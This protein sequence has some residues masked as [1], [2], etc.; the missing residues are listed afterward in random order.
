MAHKINT[1]HPLKLLVPGV[2]YLF[3]FMLVFKCSMA[4]EYKL[5]KVTPLVEI[6]GLSNVLGADGVMQDRR[7]FVWISSSN[8]LYK[9]DGY[10]TTHYA[11]DPNQPEKLAGNWTHALTEDDAGNIWIGI[12]GIGLQK[13]DPIT[14]K[15]TLYKADPAKPGGLVSNYIQSVHF[16]NGK[17]WICTQR[18]LSA[19]SPE[20]EKFK[21][22]SELFTIQTLDK[23]KETWFDQVINTGKR[24]LSYYDAASDSCVTLDTLSTMTF[25]D[26][27]ISIVNDQLFFLSN[28]K[29]YVYDLKSKI[30][31]PVKIG[32][33]DAVINVS[34]TDGQM[35]ILFSTGKIEK[36]NPE[37]GSSVMFNLG[38]AKERK[39][40]KLNEIF[41]LKNGG[42]WA[43]GDKFYKILLN[44]NGIESYELTK[45]GQPLSGFS[46]NSFSE[47]IPGLLGI[48]KSI[49]IDFN[50]LSAVN[51]AVKYPSLSNFDSAYHF[52]GRN[53][54][55]YVDENGDSWIAF[56]DGLDSPITFF[57]FS[58]A[59]RRLETLGKTDS[60]ANFFGIT[61]IKDDLWLASW[62]RL[63]KWNI[64]SSKYTFIRAGTD[65]TKLSSGGLRSC[66]KDKDDDL[67]IA[68]Q[69][70]LNL[71][72]NG[73]DYF[74]H[75]L[76]RAG[77]TTAI[78]FNSVENITQDSSGIIWIGTLGGGVNKFDKKT[79]KFS[80]ITQKQGLAG[81]SILN[82]VVDNMQNVWVSHENGISRIEAKTNRVDN[83][84]TASGLLKYDDEN[85][86]IKMK[87]GSLIFGGELITRIW[88]DK[89][90]ADTSVP[91]IFITNLKLFNK[92]LITGAADSIL[93]S[94]IFSTKSITLNYNQNVVSI[95]YAALDMSSPGE[96]TYA[97]QLV[98]FDPDWQY[99]DTKREVT[100]TNLPPAEYIFKIKS[101]N[102]YGQWHEM[103]TP[104]RIKILPPWW[105]TWWAYT[106]YALFSIAL[107]WTFISYRA[108]QLKKENLLLEEKVTRRTNELSASLTE[109]KT[110]Q[111]QL[112]QSEKM[113][114]LG[115]LTAGIAHEI[116]NPLNFV[117]NFSEVNKELLAEMKDEMNKGNIGD[118]NAIANDV[119][120]NEEKINH[121]GKRAG[122][123]VK[124][125]LQ[126]SNTSQRQKEVTDI[127]KLAD[128]YLRLSYHGFRA[129][130]KGFNAEIKTDFD[131]SIAKINIVPQD[132]GRVLLNLYN[133]AFYSVNAK[134]KQHPS[135]YEPK[136]AISTKKLNS[137][138][139]LTVTDNGD[140]IPQNIVDKIFQPFFT[141]KP[142]G[143]GTGLGLSLSYDIIK[144][145][146]GTIKAESK[147]GEATTFILHLPGI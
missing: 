19:F 23:G 135:G 118:A 67:W 106:L 8:G 99:V 117:N 5:T 31:Q 63:I 138:I 38:T 75:F 1:N 59:T 133:N 13:F 22:Y 83:Y 36:F 9:F 27:K 28:E 130:D 101:A 142:T 93:H 97:Y 39:G 21:T 17:L 66:Y 34:Y 55:V 125:M 94:S 4:Q 96:R 82:I 102:R 121:H 80:W 123:I 26:D 58:H 44:D 110:T 139:E 127:N 76:A 87:D 137:A 88:P 74:I 112:I 49:L 33:S 134:A 16:K 86:A 68:T 98:G 18:G 136:I 35:F 70:G 29:L 20:T 90:Q 104:L 60:R 2:A 54:I 92:P 11:F 64:S 12:F 61:K 115:E 52:D 30:I 37:T 124:S 40:I 85:L 119:I 78:S 32:C 103:E 120:D 114:S 126:H 3:I 144:A 7:G 10:S 84:T 132:I 147:E 56:K 45:N 71:K 53:T 62:G 46:P 48:G 6:P 140:G 81:T 105:K 141:T 79:G 111:S 89:I 25:N 128:E 131:N 107:I 43:L 100:Y 41:T 24:V 116:Q 57:K 146:N 69:N 113:A 77:D 143:Q 91:P 122:A 95:E 108:R 15:F 145:H 50:N 65:S 73:Q 72:K 129:K 14:E 47:W 51:A 109:L 42:V